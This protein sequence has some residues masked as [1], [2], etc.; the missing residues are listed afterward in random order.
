[1]TNVCSYRFLQVHFLLEHLT[2][3]VKNLLCNIRCW[4]LSMPL[5]YEIVLCWSIQLL[6][7]WVKLIELLVTTTLL[8]ILTFLLIKKETFPFPY[9]FSL[10]LII[11]NG[12][13]LML[14]MY[15]FL[16]FYGKIAFICSEFFN[17]N[18]T[19]IYELSL[20]SFSHFLT[21]WPITRWQNFRL[22]QIET[23]CRWHF[24]VHLICKISTI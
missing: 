2:D 9:L 24:K 20:I 14:G 15:F 16:V 22:V 8:T 21:L 18:L 12:N 13:P 17:F 19:C 5:E 23:N 7:I 3:F 11:Q 4:F 1:M 6:K 10:S